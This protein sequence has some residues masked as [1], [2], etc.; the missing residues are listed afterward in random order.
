MINVL[1]V[2]NRV[3]SGGHD[4][5]QGKIISRYERALDLIKSLVPVCDICDICHIYDNSYNK[6][7]RFFKKRK[8]ECFYEE[9][10]IWKYKN[11]SRLINME[12][13]EKKKL[14]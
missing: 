14:N 10:G 3:L 11:I 8:N 7:F 12:A 4:V 2:R 13:M 6:P 5:P 1:R 9:N